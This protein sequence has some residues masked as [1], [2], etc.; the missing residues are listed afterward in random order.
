[1]IT[2]RKLTAIYQVP[3]NRYGAAINCVLRF[4]VKPGQQVMEAA[5]EAAYKV[6]KKNKTDLYDIDSSITHIFEGWVVDEAGWE[7]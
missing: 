1:M 3:V 7:S 6:Q 4:E 2:K 5:N